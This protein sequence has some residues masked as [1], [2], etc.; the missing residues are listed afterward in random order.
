M[1]HRT[2]YSE[3]NHFLYWVPP[4]QEELGWEEPTKMLRMTYQEW[5]Q[6]ADT[7]DDQLGPHMP[8]WY[9]RLIGC[10]GMGNDGSCVEGSSEYLFDEL[11][12]F[13]FDFVF[14]V[15]SRLAS[16]SPMLAPFW[17]PLAPLERPK[18]SKQ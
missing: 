11:P 2:E 7:S 13:Y 15:Y 8:H 3:S 16:W 14:D 6:H 5:L 9:F 17:P 4:A 10:G 12:F 1:R 18:G